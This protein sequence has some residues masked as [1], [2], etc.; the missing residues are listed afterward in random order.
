MTGVMF[1]PAVGGRWVPCRLIRPS[2][3]QGCWWIEVVDDDVNQSTG[4]WLARPD[5][6]KPI[7]R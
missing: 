5:Q 7:P 2:P 6:L 3:A 1:R 4:V